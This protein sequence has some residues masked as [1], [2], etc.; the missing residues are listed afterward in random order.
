[1]DDT[2]QEEHYI[3]AIKRYRIHHLSIEAKRAPEV[4]E[5][6]MD[7]GPVWIYEGYYTIEAPGFAGIIE[8]ST[9]W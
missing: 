9:T 3:Q 4:F 2:T 1:M 6:L 7:L 5:R 8:T